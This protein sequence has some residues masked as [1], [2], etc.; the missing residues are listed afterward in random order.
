MHKIYQAEKQKGNQMDNPYI[1]YQDEIT[2]KE[3]MN[4]S[5][6]DKKNIKKIEIVP[7]KLGR[8]DFGKIRINLKTPIYKTPWQ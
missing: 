6:K 7:P 8:A 2:P 1:S 5:E 3:F 4:L